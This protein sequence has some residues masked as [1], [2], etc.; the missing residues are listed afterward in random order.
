IAGGIMF[1]VVAFL[2]DVIEGLLVLFIPIYAIVYLCKN[3]ETQ[4]WFCL[5]L[6]S[7]VCLFT[8]VGE[9]A[10]SQFG[11]RARQNA[12]AFQQA[13]FQPPLVQRP[14]QPP[15][16]QP[17]QQ[18]V[19]RP[20]APPS[21]PVAGPVAPNVTGNP[22]LDKLLADLESEDR[23]RVLS[24]TSD[25]FLMPM[26]PEHQPKVFAKLI[27]IAKAPF[28]LKRN[29]QR[30]AAE[31]VLRK[32]STKNDIPALLEL[33]KGSDPEGIDISRLLDIVEP[34]HDERTI[35]LAIEAMR[36]KVPKAKALA[37]L[38][39]MGSKPEPFVLPLLKE[40]NPVLVLE[41]IYLLRDIGTSASIPALQ[42]LVT[43][44][45]VRLR[46]AARA[47]TKSIKLRAS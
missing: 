38:R 8:A 32:W 34:F 47:A 24:A 25:L 9:S 6:V 46:S 20:V 14:I 36:L 7:W 30:I 43:G 5:S 39:T 41:A 37:A 10:I 21:P 42:P 27:A 31:A 40:S 1:I 15:V 12:P 17:V 45:V 33:R 35:P 13:Q 22:Q 28:D 16:Q 29:Y 18:P 4:G 23:Q 19:Q 2:D 11:D 3:P 44:P 26:L